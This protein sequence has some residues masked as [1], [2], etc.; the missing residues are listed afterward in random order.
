MSK[1]TY[2]ALTPQ[3][4]W[5]F[6]DG[7]PYNKQESNQADAV[8][9]FP[10][11][12]R[13]ITGAF[14]A[15]LAR[16]NGWKKGPTWDCRL[17][18]VLGNGPDELGALQGIG[19]FLVKKDQLLFP[20]PLHLMGK[21]EEKTW[22][23]QALLRP[24]KKETLTDLGKVRLPEVALKNPPDGLKPG[25]K[26]WIN[27]AGYNHILAG[28]LPEATDL[29]ASDCLRK[30]ERRVGLQR[31]ASTL[32]TEEGAL[33]SP[34]FVRLCKDVALGFGVALDP[35]KVPAGFHADMPALFPLGGE[36]RTTLCEPL[37]KVECLPLPPDLTPDGDLVHFIVVA[38]TPVP[39]Q[40]EA[41]ITAI[42]GIAGVEPVSACVGK[43]VFFG[44]WDSVKREPLPLEPFHPAGSVWFC[45]APA[46]ALSSIR[47]LHGKWIGERRLTAHGFGQ[48]LIGRWPM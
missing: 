15:A 35:M 5:F 33:Y 18:P 44:G 28:N 38:L 30:L 16:A 13:T 27:A 40:E 45:K 24:G 10:P 1:P 20:A 42:L 37:E 6:R 7:R 29:T 8:S 26:R 21:M 12:P 9:Q 4:A 11:S 32:Q 34:G 2:Y 48:M 17:N 14:R 22:K 3:D 47:A 39:A 36:S 19:P 23:P 43:P 46:S 41:N 25:E 31:N